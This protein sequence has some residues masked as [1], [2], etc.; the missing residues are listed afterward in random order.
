MQD[1]ERQAQKKGVKLERL[2]RC[3]FCGSHTEHGVFEC[4]EIFN[5]MA[6]GAVGLSQF[7][8]ADAHCLQH[9]EVHGTW[10]NNFHLTRMYL[11]LEKKINWAYS[12][13]S[14][15]SS[16]L[17]KYKSSH[18]EALIPALPRLERDQTTITDLKGL[19]RSEFDTALLRWAHDVYE[20]YAHYHPIAKAVGDLYIQNFEK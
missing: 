14:H 20:S 9:S 1:I 3:Q 4:F 2:G 11:T 10:N 18:A 5:F 19:K 8:Y 13:T 17:D 6:S 7:I 16:T 15:L 12:K